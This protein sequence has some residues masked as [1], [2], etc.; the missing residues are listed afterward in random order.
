MNDELYKCLDCPHLRKLHDISKDLSSERGIIA[1]VSNIARRFPRLQVLFLTFEAYLGE[2][3]SLGSIVPS[4]STLRSITSFKLYIP[5]DWEMPGATTDVDIHALANA[6]PLLTTLSI[7]ADTP[8]SVSP[9]ALVSLATR[10]PK[11]EV[12]DLP[13]LCILEDDLSSLAADYPVPVL[14]HALQTISFRRLDVADC[15]Y[16]ASLLDRLFPRLYGIRGSAS[17][18]FAHIRR[19]DGRPS[20]L[21][22]QVQ[23]Q[24]EIV[25]AAR[26]QGQKALG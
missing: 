23:A 22:D 16:A 14:D 5:T 20:P 9:A 15:K 21:Y 1:R 24:L 2:D 8:A 3:F 18:S 4:L 7:Y 13:S 11:L 26:R 10:C 19:F 12:L 6:W 17:P 25:Q